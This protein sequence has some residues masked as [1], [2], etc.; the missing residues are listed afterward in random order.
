MNADQL[1]AGKI[2]WDLF[3][4]LWVR[5]PG[6]I[7]ILA[8]VLQLAAVCTYCPQA[9]GQATAARPVLGAPAY[10]LVDADSGQVLY[11]HNIYRPM[12]P[13]STT[14]IMTAILTLDYL[15]LDEE[16]SV[17]QRAAH[18]PPSGIGLKAGQKMRVEDLLK[19]VLVTSAND[20]S[21]VLA[22][23][24][25][26]SEEVFS[27]LMN[28][29]ALIIG[30]RG[31]SFKNANGLPARGHLSTCY[32]LALISRYAL[33]SPAFAETVALTKT[34]IQHP[35]YPGG[36]TIS[37]TNRLLLM[38]PGCKGVKTGTTNAAGKC[39]VSYAARNNRRLLAVILRSPDRYGESIKL[40]NY[41]F[42]NFK[43]VC[44]VDHR[45]PF[46]RIKVENGIP[47]RLTVY[48]SR[49]IYLLQ[50]PGQESLVEKNV[51]ME[52]SPRAPIKKGDKLG[53]VE[54]YYNGEF[55]EAAGLIAGNN[56][57]REPEGLW[58]LLPLRR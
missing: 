53:R 37:N 20:A 8:V 38:Y 44:V 12:P 6:R 56:I 27:Y 5:P 39:L 45:Y 14:K 54:V 19:A 48:P 21:V 42:N 16:A 7:L 25:A 28:K 49:D 36:K 17:S 58:R 33:R 43:P 3:K 52:Y 9:R 23:R 35:G 26:G 10:I 30:A 51:F 29:K 57:R 13:A 41:G 15:K 46:K 18:T 50:A 22:E 24:I 47:S 1:K 4:R 34:T 40:L 55:L 31:T 2:I 11:G 32:D